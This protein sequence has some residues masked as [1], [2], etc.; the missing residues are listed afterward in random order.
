MISRRESLVKNTPYPEK[1]IYLCFEGMIC[2]LHDQLWAAQNLLCKLAS[3]TFNVQLNAMVW[4]LSVLEV[5]AERPSTSVNRP[6]KSNL[7]Y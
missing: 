1:I 5:F 7:S 2:S 4:Q 6:Q 3:G